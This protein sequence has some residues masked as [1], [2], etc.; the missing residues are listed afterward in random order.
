[1][2]QGQSLGNKG[3]GSELHAGHKEHCL[4]AMREMPPRL[5]M[6]LFNLFDA[7]S[8]PAWWAKT[9]ETEGDATCKGEE[10]TA[11]ET[12]DLGD[13]ASSAARSAACEFCCAI[14]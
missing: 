11:A 1:M 5:L 2:D 3:P 6:E 10:A 7:E 4:C 8:L 14:R 12:E 13:L 9:L